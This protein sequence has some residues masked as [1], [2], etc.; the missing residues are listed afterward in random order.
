MLPAHDKNIL[1]FL[2]TSIGLIVL[3]HGYHL[4]LPVFGF[5]I[6]L[7]SW[8]FLAIWHQASMPKGVVL[9]FLAICGLAILFKQFHTLL[10]RDAGT[11]LFLIALG[12]KLMEIKSEREIYLVNYLAFIV[13][14]SQFLY[15]QSILMAAYIL[16]VSCVLLATLVYINSVVAQTGVALKKA[17][18]IIAQAIPMTIVVFIL[19][20][21]VEPPRWLL[22][23]DK[24]E[25]RMGLSDSMEPGSITNLG[26]SEEL[27]FRVTFIGAPPPPRE[28]YWRG[29]VLT[30]TDGKKWQQVNDAAY[31]RFQDKVRFSGTAYNYTLMLEPQN[32]NWVFALD[33]PAEFPGTL[34]R[35][36]NYQLVSQDDLGK[37]SEYKL[38]SY[39]DFNTGFITQLE[40]KN[41]RQLPDTPS[42]N[43]KRLVAQLHGFGST[44]EVFIE[45]LLNHFRQE[46]FHYTLTPP[47]MEDNPIE[48]FLFESRRGFCSHYAAAFV[49]LMRVA[50]IPSRVVTGYQGGVMNA[51]G[52][53]L[54]IRQA[55]AHAW[56]EVWLDK[57]GWV[58]VDPTAAIAPE[59]IEREID[60]NQLTEGE[61]IQ[62]ANPSV[63][64]KGAFGWL[65]RAQQMWGH[66]DYSWQRWVINY[67]NTNQASFLS[68]FGI[69]DFKTMVYWM[70]G[71]V[72]FFTAI[73][74][75]ILLYRR[76]K[77]TDRMVQL[78]NKFLKKIAKAGYQ[79]QPGEGARAFA[80]RIKPTLPGYA[81]SI[82]NITAEFIVQRYGKEPTQAG[83]KNLQLMIKSLKL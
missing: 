2:L 32:K 50:N 66:V 77:Q 63:G 28:R 75:A 78:Y 29:P 37:R 31:K 57:K 52:N 76:P 70:M 62:F 21:R 5:F 3:P 12:L 9:A 14:A 40:Y 65:K 67:N 42:D 47:L 81:T 20:P 25:A 27:V 15:E 60:I 38:T 16:F 74:S 79:K 82:E 69:T 43:I 51:V 35:N 13:A 46:D 34:S 64:A 61:L 68:L 59:R 39:P 73:L 55:D 36:G 17:A 6:L 80:E 4:P 7:L 30:Y 10:G 71:I 83:F 54:E 44:P 56:A 19:F 53:F 24:Q 45:Q 33:M 26:M 41:S 11:S 1:I 72:G 22:F 23:N 18:V 8:R 48:T 49:Y 58:R